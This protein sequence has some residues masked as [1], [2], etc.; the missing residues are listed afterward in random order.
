MN[1]NT[2]L[3]IVVVLLL[4]AAATYGYYSTTQGPEQQQCT[5]EAKICPDGSAVGRTGPDCSFAACPGETGNDGADPSQGI[6]PYDSGVRGTVM[7]GPTCPVERMPP[8]PNC[9]D[10]P[11]QT[12]VTIFRANDLTHAFVLTQS[13]ANGRFSAALPPGDYVLGAGEAALPDCDNPTVSVEPRGYASVV[14]SCDSGI[15]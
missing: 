4:L 9:A 7:V 10:K 15:R 14:I 12:L 6:L 2:T 3:G 5:L 1:H 11:F 13:D 8:D